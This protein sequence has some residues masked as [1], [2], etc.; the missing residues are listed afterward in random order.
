FHTCP[1]PLNPAAEYPKKPI[2]YQLHTAAPVAADDYCMNFRPENQ[3]GFQ[4]NHIYHLQGKH[5]H[6]C[7]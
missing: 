3:R 7:C 5:P 2:A 6:G 1:H 4:N